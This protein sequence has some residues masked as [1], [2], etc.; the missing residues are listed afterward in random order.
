[1]TIGDGAWI[2]SGAVIM[3]GV[4]IGAGAVIGANSLVTKDCA[5]HTLHLGSP[6][7]HVRDLD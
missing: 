5:P 4:S 6:A 2:G 3:P 1:M 7:R